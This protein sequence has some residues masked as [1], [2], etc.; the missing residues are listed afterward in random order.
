M[1]LLQALVRAYVVTSC[2]HGQGFEEPAASG[3]EAAL[4]STT[5]P[6]GPGGTHPIDDVLDRS[7]PQLLAIPGVVGAG[8]GRTQDGDDAVIVWVTDPTA[9]E[10]LPTDLE[11]FTVIVKTVPGGFRALEG[12]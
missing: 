1:R 2:A 11:G 4:P 10:N 8:H 9:A 6:S 7:R 3:E 5:P 12:Q